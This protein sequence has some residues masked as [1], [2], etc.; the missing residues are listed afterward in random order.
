MNIEDSGEGIRFLRSLGTVLRLR[1]ATPRQAFFEGGDKKISKDTFHGQYMHL[2][3]TIWARANNIKII[4]STAGK[5][6][7]RKTHN[8]GE[9]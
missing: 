2:H 6:R 7:V 1:K 4:V 3:A 8:Y 5:G 9:L